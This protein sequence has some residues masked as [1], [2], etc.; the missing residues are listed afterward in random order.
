MRLLS[1]VLICSLVLVA[2]NKN[3]DSTGTH[4]LT[5]RFRGT[6]NR[7]TSPDT[8]QVSFNFKPD[9]T[10]E[11]TGGPSYYPSI[12]SGTFQRSNNTLVINDS[13][14]WTANFDWTLIF[15]GTYN[16]NFTSENKVRIWRTTG[17]FTDEYLL[18]RI[19]R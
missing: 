18:N 1:M 2:C 7:S 11:G 5:G 9:M 3:N 10:Y 6:F 19:V 12:C 14:A 4:E 16:I 17:A 15:D 13:C 8:A